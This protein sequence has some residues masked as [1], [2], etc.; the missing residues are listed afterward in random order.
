M[1]TPFVVGRHHPIS[2]G[3]AEKL[4]VGR[5]HCLLSYLRGPDGARRGRREGRKGGAAGDGGRVAE[6]QSP[7]LRPEVLLDGGQPPSATPVTAMRQ[8]PP[9]PP[10]RTRRLLSH[11]V[12]S[13]TAQPATLLRR[14]DPGRCSTRT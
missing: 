12:V 1:T 11:V 14:R 10:G 9:R 6:P 5:R 2:G 8:E 3:A 7:P 4:T 13:R